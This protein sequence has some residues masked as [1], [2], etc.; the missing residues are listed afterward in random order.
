VHP[1]NP[2][3]LSM[4]AGALPGGDPRGHAT[5]DP[6]FL[7]QL[8][9]RSSSYQHQAYRT[10]KTFCRWAVETGIL[11]QDLVDPWPAQPWLRSHHAKHTRAALPQLNRCFRE[12]RMPRSKAQSLAEVQAD[13]RKMVPISRR[14]QLSS[15]T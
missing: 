11:R 4:V 12:N 14:R 8:Q 9:F 5:G 1:G 6:H 15:R 13:G 7:R 3:D 10:L 2:E